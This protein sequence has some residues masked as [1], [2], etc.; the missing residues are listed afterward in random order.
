MSEE[1]QHLLMFVVG[2]CAVVLVAWAPV[3]CSRSS[4]EAILEAIKSGTPALE[5][6]CA[7]SADQGYCVKELGGGR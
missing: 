3:S 7:F 2:A 4:D 1:M 5:A 6:K